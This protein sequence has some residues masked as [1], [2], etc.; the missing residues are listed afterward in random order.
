M[1]RAALATNTCSLACVRKERIEALE[2]TTPKRPPLMESES[3]TSAA[4]RVLVC[5]W[6]IDSLVTETV[7]RWP[8][9]VGPT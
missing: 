3:L 9:K 7:D 1:T 4:L 6:F 5:W 8:H 2:P